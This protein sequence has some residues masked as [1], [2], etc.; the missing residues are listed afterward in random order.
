MDQVTT[1]IYTDSIQVN[2]RCLDEVELTDSEQM[3]HHERGRSLE[4]SLRALGEFDQF[5]LQLIDWMLEVGANNK[6]AVFDSWSFS[7]KYPNG[8]RTDTDQGN[9]VSEMYLRSEHPWISPVVK[10]VFVCHYVVKR[11][12]F[13][14]V[15]FCF[16]PEVM[17]RPESTVFLRFH[18]FSFCPRTSVGTLTLTQVTKE[19]LS[20]V[21]AFIKCSEEDREVIE[22]IVSD[23]EDPLSI[24]LSIKQKPDSDDLEITVNNA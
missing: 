12:G 15:L 19:E 11:L 23:S 20:E 17:T 4:H 22:D 24:E 5:R 18:R 10:L 14:A 6:T 2:V 13:M 21:L 7:Y 3:E 1:V 8:G 16:S 9:F